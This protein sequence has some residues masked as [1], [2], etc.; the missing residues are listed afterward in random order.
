ML[1]VTK[2]LFG[3]GRHGRPL[4][5][6][7]YYFVTGTGNRQRDLGDLLIP[8]KTINFKSSLTLKFIIIPTSTFLTAYPGRS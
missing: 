6:D 2:F 3:L 8:T 5:E 4:I 1:P 7:A